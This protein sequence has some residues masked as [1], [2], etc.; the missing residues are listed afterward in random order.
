MSELDFNLPSGFICTNCKTIYS[1][2]TPL[3]GEEPED[4]YCPACG[5]YWLP[6]SRKWHP[7]KGSKCVGA[8][9][10][11]GGEG[12]NWSVDIETQGG[13]TSVESPIEKGPKV[14]I[15]EK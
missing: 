3:S 8:Y 9:S 10:D 6:F 12:P 14:L 11:I 13:Y 4:D 15:V 1:A 7:D 2:P 5:E